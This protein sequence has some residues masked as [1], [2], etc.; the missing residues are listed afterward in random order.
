MGDA[1]RDGGAG[2]VGAIE[3]FRDRDG[4]VDSPCGIIAAGDEV[5]FTSI[6]NGRVGRVRRHGRAQ[7]FVVETFADPRS[8]VRL[9][10]NIFPAADGRLWFTCL[11]SDALASIDPDAADP[12]GSIAVHA[13]P[14][15]RGPVAIKAAGTGLLWFTVRGSQA[16][17]SIDPR[18]P[19]P[20]ASLRLVR[21]SL[22][23]DPSA[24]FVDA[25][26]RVWWVNAGSGA[27]GR[28]E[29]AGLGPTGLGHAGA[30]AWFGPWPE[31]GSP[32]AWAMDRVGALWL[33]T[34]ERPGLLRIDGS[35]TGRPNLSWH[36]DESLRTPDG[37]WVAA[38]GAVWL[39]DTA[40][41]AIVRF[42]PATGDWR[43]Y[44]GPGV[45]G[46]FDL[47]PGPDPSVFWFTNKRG[48]SIGRIRVL[49]KRGRA[50]DL[51]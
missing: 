39:A 10:A 27:L 45:A 22:I 5:W 14:D 34:W 40:A 47:K 16:I 41:D 7:R 3:V 1:G 13:H 20:T 37:V 48:G 15:L 50:V 31:W 25:R 23:A 17:G 33:T 38:D 9:P 28:L 4:C 32:R 35:G 2:G 6:A 24:L 11:G 18:A 42:D 49:A 51:R 30:V 36:T 29:P 46:P 21:S 26:G 19:R 12:A 8:R 43:G 44:T